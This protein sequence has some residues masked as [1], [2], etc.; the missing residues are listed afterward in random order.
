MQTYGLHRGSLFG[1]L[2]RLQTTK[3]I[4]LS[5]EGQECLRHNPRRIIGWHRRILFS[6]SAA[7]D[8]NNHSP[9]L[10]PSHPLALQTFVIYVTFDYASKTDYEKPIPVALDWGSTLL[11]EVLIPIARSLLSRVRQFQPCCADFQV[12]MRCSY[13]LTSMLKTSSSTNLST[14]ATQSTVKYDEVD[15][16]GK[17]VEKSSESRKIVKKLKKPQRS[18]NFHGHRFGGTF[19]KAPILRQ[20][21]RASVRA[22]TIFRAL[23]AGPKNLFWGHFCFNYRQGKANG[24]VDVLLQFSP[25]EAKSSSQE[26]SNLL[27]TQWPSVS[28]FCLYNA[29]PPSVTSILKICFGRRRPSLGM[30]G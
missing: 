14:N 3:Q 6:D 21:I 4:E 7:A 15:V 16:G 29:C 20:R 19:T 8:I 5:L 24:A 17:L 25:I 13:P 26:H 18:E 22:L 11:D 28:K 12:F 23:F 2:T 9:S 10:N 1:W 30:M 27:P